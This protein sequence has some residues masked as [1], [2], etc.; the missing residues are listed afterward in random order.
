MTTAPT[1]T[2]KPRR[3]WLQFSLRTLLVLMLVTS[4][5]LG[6]LTYKLKQAREQRATIDAIHALGGRASRSCQ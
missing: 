3:R 1:T 4:V 2:R 5:P 6:R